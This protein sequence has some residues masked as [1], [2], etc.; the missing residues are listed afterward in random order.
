M[1]DIRIAEHYLSNTNAVSTSLRGHFINPAIT[2]PQL[3]SGQWQVVA[4][5]ESRGRF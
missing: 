1:S 3:T 5:G 2:V 4:I